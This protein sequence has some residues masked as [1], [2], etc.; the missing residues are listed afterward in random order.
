MKILRSDNSGEYFSKEFVKFCCG[1]G[2]TTE[3]MK[4]TPEKTGPERKNRNLI[5]MTRCM[6]YS[7][8]SYKCFWVE[9][10]C[11]ANF[12]LNR[13]PTNEILQVTPEEKWNGRKP[14]ISNFKIFGNECWAHIPD[15]KMENVRAQVT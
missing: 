15:K 10:R 5:E 14:Y 1:V 8:G 6:L 2:I 12:I 9:S 7:K 11:C 3:R 13:V 4:P